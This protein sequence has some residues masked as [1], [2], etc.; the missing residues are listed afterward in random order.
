MRA[1]IIFASNLLD[2][3]KRY[4]CVHRTTDFI[5]RNFPGI[6]KYT[7][8][9]VDDLTFEIVDICKYLGVKVNSKNDMLRETHERI[10]SGSRRYL[11]I[12]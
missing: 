9:Q 5:V 11:G 8:I 1:I 4:I 12:S 7:S 3:R 10:V 2:H 6:N